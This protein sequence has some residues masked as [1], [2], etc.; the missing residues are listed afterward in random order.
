LFQRILVL[1]SVGHAGMGRRV[2]TPAYHSNN[3]I[4]NILPMKTGSLMTGLVLAVAMSGCMSVRIIPESPELAAERAR[5]RDVQRAGQ[6]DALGHLALGVELPADPRE[7]S[8]ARG[9]IESL[10][11][12]RV[13][14]ASSPTCW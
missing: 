2:A 12:A 6:G 1:L 3:T 5:G 9:F 8:A 10:R 7:E 4:L 11:S 13:S 14:T